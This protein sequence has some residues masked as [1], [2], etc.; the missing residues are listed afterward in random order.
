MGDHPRHWPFPED[1]SICAEPGKGSMSSACIIRPHPVPRPPAHSL[2]AAHSGGGGGGDDA[3]AQG[4]AAGPPL[5][6]VPRGRADGAR[7]ESWAGGGGVC[8]CGERGGSRRLCA[9]VVGEGK[10]RVGRG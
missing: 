1:I 5:L 2:T 3:G 4:P 8:V 7:A 10:T 6:P 9:R